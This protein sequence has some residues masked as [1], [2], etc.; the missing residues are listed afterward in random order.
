MEQ[1][2]GPP[3]RPAT[4]RS[5]RRVALIYAAGLAALLAALA[6]CGPLGDDDPDPTRTLGPAQPP[7]GSVSSPVMSTFTPTVP[8]ST[9]EALQTAAARSTVQAVTATHEADNPPPT[10]TLPAG[11]P[12]TD[13]PELRLPKAQLSDGAGNIESTEGSYSWLYDDANQTYARFEVP[14]M[15]FTEV[16][17]TTSNLDFNIEIPDVSDPVTGIAI[18]AYD[19]TA[20]T[21]IPVDQAGQPGERLMFSPKEAPVAETSAAALG[22]FFTLDLAP[23]HYI[24]M[25][26]V[27]WPD[28]VHQ[29]PNAAAQTFPIYITYIFNVIIE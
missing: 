8:G 25:A 4:P 6:A 15:E 7:G 16:A 23:G 3:A 10:P 14:L 29:P 1:H 22:E 28:Y 13:M 18:Q 26:E 12:T 5:F 9:P 2:S 24:F 11:L 27:A 19:F 21:A 20:N 17:L